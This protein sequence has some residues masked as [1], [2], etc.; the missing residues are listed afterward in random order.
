MVSVGTIV[1]KSPTCKSFVPV[2][3]TRGQS[4]ETGQTEGVDQHASK[5]HHCGLTI[6]LC[7]SQSVRPC[8][9]PSYGAKKEVLDFC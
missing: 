4:G 6:P 7:L 8:F 3:R 2:D 1:S 5:A 9:I